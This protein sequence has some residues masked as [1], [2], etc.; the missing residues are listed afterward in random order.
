MQASQRYCSCTRSADIELPSGWFLYQREIQPLVP[1][2]AQLEFLY[3]DYGGQADFP[4]WLSQATNLKALA[5]PR[6]Q[7]FVDSQE[8]RLLSGY[9]NFTFGIDITG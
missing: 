3:I 6:Y 9:Y 5:M 7:P 4:E 2:P 8:Q 1:D